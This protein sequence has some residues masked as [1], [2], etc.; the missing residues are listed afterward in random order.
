MTDD[1]PREARERRA[2]L[3]ERR[4]EEAAER[5]MSD[6]RY[7]VGLEFTGAFE[8]APDLAPG[9]RWVFRFCGEWIGSATTEAEA[10]AI[11]KIWKK[12]K[13]A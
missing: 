8:P 2:R 9:Q 7:H 1:T 10:W 3:A 13:N 5:I 11:A 4:Q 6:G 12:E